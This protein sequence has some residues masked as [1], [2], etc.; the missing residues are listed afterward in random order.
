MSCMVFKIYFLNSC[1]NNVQQKILC[2]IVW[3]D[4]KINNFIFWLFLFCLFF[5]DLFPNYREALVFIKKK[6]EKKE[7]GESWLVSKHCVCKCCYTRFQNLNWISGAWA[8]CVPQKALSNNFPFL[9][10]QSLPWLTLRDRHI[11]FG[12]ASDLPWRTQPCSSVWDLL[13]TSSNIFS[14]LV[15]F[16]MNY[17][18][19]FRLPA[20][21]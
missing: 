7:D 21:K 19:A 16:L 8:V 1:L 3:F 14:S 9:S 4:S 12:L 5:N 2:N 10:W 20:R 13:P 15:I 11:G 6:K 18:F 17:L